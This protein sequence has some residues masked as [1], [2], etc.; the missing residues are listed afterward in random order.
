M[1]KQQQQFIEKL[2]EL[3]TSVIHKITYLVSHEE[4]QCMLEVIDDLTDTEGNI[5]DRSLTH[6]YITLLECMISYDEI[7]VDYYTI[8]ESVYR[9]YMKHKHIRDINYI[10]DELSEYILYILERTDTTRST[11]GL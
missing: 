11:I 3:S 6:S 4:L 9:Y 2:H 5:D 8:G 1:N 7:K 10:I